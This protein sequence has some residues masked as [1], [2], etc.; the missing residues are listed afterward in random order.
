M[1]QPNPLSV[2]TQA[3]P[4]SP[5]FEYAFEP[6]SPMKKAKKGADTFSHFSRRYKSQLSDSEVFSLRFN[7]DT[8]LTGITFTDGSLQIISSMLGDKLYHIHNDDMKTP[9]TG[10]AWK[11]TMEMTQD[12]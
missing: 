10:M 7:Q 11:P 5:R 2:N 9:I 3:K 12:A 4:E 8:S 6:H 1:V